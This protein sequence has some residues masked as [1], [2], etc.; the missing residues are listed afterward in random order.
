MEVRQIQQ[1][2]QDTERGN[3]MDVFWGVP[4]RFCKAVLSS[5]KHPWFDH[6][7]GNGELCWTKQLW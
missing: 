2:L 1:G 4:V 3:T 6:F 7:E 5:G